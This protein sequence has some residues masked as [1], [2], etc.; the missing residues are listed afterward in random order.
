M[1]A[2]PAIES[3]ELVINWHI[4]EACNYE[5]RYCYAKWQSAES[6]RELIHDRDGT[7][8]LLCE[9]YNYF[10]PENKANPLRKEMNWTSLRL[11]LAGGEPLLYQRCVVETIKAARQFGFSVSIITN[12]SRL[13]S[14]LMREIAPHLSVLGVSLDSASAQTNL[15]IGRT[16][17]QGQSL[18]MSDLTSYLAMAKRI[19]PQLKLKINTVV[20]ALNWH[21]DMNDLVTS[22]GPVK[23]KIFRMLP[24][25]TDDL[26]VSEEEF[27]HFVLRHQSLKQVMCAEDNVDMAESYLMIDP[28]GRFFQNS[29]GRRGYDYSQPILEAGAATAF[30]Q[31]GLSASKFT[32]RY[33]TLSIGERS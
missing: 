9:I 25:V 24:T 32:S 18:F 14:A 33:T 11:N 4:T 16:D 10:K 7:L 3:R 23:W 26:A 29:L 19:N 31:I 6:M 12:G 22:L 21:Q 1:T 27:Q 15:E 30:S 5:C 2:Q 20:N 8:K 13:N 17:R 28:L